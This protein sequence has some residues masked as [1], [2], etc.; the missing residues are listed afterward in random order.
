MR[1]VLLSL[2]ALILFYSRFEAEIF[3]VL[4]ANQEAQQEVKALPAE[5]VDL[6]QNLLDLTYP[7]TIMCVAAHPDDEDSDGLAFYRM[8]YGARTVIV[9]ATR[10]EGG[11]NSQGEELYEDLAVKRVSELNLAARRLDAATFNL[12]MPD[13]GFSPSSEETFQ[14]WNRREA[15]RR[16]VFA[17]RTFRPDIIITQHDRSTGH[18]HHQAT[19]RL[20][21]EA[22]DVAAD[23]YAFSD[24]I[25]LRLE[26]WQVK[27]LFVKTQSRTRYDTEF[28]TNAIEPIRKKPY[29]IISYESR[30]EHRTQG[31]W[32]EVKTSSERMSRYNLVKKSQGDT[33]RRWFT[34]DQGIEEPAIYNKIK[35]LLF[36]QQYST[37]DKLLLLPEKELVFRLVQALKLVEGYIKQEGKEDI[38]ALELLTKLQK[39]LLT[40]CKIQLSIKPNVEK[41]FPGKEFSFTASITNGCTFNLETKAVRVLLPDGWEVQ[42]KSKFP[43]KL[44]PGTTV[45]AEFSATVATEAATTLPATAHIY[46]IDFLEPQIDLSA[47]ISVAEAEL[48]IREN[49][50]IEIAPSIEVEVTPSDATLN[51]TSSFS[52]T[53]QVIQV[54]VTNNSN[55]QLKARLMA[56][57]APRVRLSPEV[58]QFVVAPSSIATISL[59]A[60]PSSIKEGG[61][62]II[63]PITISDD[64]GTVLSTN[65]F[66]LNILTVNVAKN[67]R[68]GYLRTYDLT[69]LRA[70]SVMGID[71]TPMSYQQLGENGLNF[72]YDT[73]VIDNRA[74]LAYP[75]ISKFNSNLLDFVKA[76]GTVIVFYQRPVDWNNKQLSPFPLTLGDQR[77]TDERAPVSILIED[78][79]IVNKP[80]RLESI[81]FDNWIQERGLYFP[82]SWDEK[83]ETVLSSGDPGQQQLKGGLLVANY[84][85]GHYI[86]TSYAISR[87]L[88]SQVTGAYKLF[89]NMISYPKSR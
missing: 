69:L 33:F 86:Y 11:Q 22:I 14:K 64:K 68:V 31:P 40:T 89:A 79:P 77:V 72:R 2:V 62:N 52:V 21:E 27:R 66:R 24:Q 35:P 49:A 42:E 26:P 46:D 20:T 84:G 39:S 15:V 74:Y 43:E 47:K 32:P 57:Q 54:K 36:D 37:V 23:K 18:G 67:L 34:F 55:Q 10:G 9:T 87:Q 30:L 4:E 58:Q 3:G 85:R 25:K 48:T 51:L 29:S 7:F 44:E 50:R 16:L 5:Q 12:A 82:E 75:D 80:N 88:R 1:K 13:F 59:T 63:L 60:T 19:R 65:N 41:T 17:I 73:I 6:Y 81:D 78:H 56:T 38:K 83:Y 53:P 28:D 45:S 8:K 61:D 76:G 71:A 70:F